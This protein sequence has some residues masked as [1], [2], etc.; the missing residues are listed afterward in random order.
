MADKSWYAGQSFMR[1]VTN[2]CV[3]SRHC[4]ITAAHATDTYSGS[5]PSGEGVIFLRNSTVDNVSPVIT[6][7]LS[8]R[9]AC[10]ALTPPNKSIT[11]Y[12]SGYTWTQDVTVYSDY[13]DVLT[14][15]TTACTCACYIRPG[16]FSTQEPVG[17]VSYAGYLST[18][19]VSPYDGAVVREAWAG[20]RLGGPSQSARRHRV[21]SSFILHSTQ[22]PN[23][24]RRPNSS[25][26]HTSTK[27]GG[28]HPP[29]PSTYRTSL[30][31]ALT[32]RA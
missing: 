15:S 19:G 28:Q 9:H 32:S 26:V 11:E 29:N 24:C 5:F 12:P 13:G 16:A 3:G 21:G 31:A 4:T 8:C 27:F 18:T 22:T 25:Q 20:E 10:A 1:D 7:K 30:P 17:K 6:D 23:H 14:L 2:A